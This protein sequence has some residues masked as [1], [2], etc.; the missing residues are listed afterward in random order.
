MAGP[1]ILIKMGDFVA[2]IGKPDDL[3]FVDGVHDDEWGEKTLSLTKHKAESLI[4]I[5][6][7]ESDF[8]KYWRVVKH[9]ISPMPRVVGAY[10]DEFGDRYVD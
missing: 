10:N 6:V 3:Y 7:P 1:L 8:G 9:N 5:V 2:R 4:R